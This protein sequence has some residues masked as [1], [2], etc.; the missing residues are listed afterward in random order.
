MNTS[1]GCGAVLI[2]ETVKACKGK[3]KT[4]YVKKQLLY[5]TESAAIQILKWILISIY[6]TVDPFLQKQPVFDTYFSHY[7][8][9][10]TNKT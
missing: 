8:M 4:R 9:P 3:R 5:R 2:T 7:F 1:R 6:L 10:S